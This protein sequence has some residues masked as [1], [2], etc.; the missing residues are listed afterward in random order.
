[1][2][3]LPDPAAVT[4]APVDQPATTTAPVPAPAPADT[5]K[6]ETNSEDVMGDL[7]VDDLDDLFNMDDYDENAN[8]EHSEFEKAWFNFDD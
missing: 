5:P 8:P 6:P 7:V 4:K 2:A 3:D 1:M